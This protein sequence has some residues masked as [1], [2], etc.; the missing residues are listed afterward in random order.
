MST[1]AEPHGER[2]TPC[3]MSTKKSRSKAEVSL[4]LEEP[5]VRS[6]VAHAMSMQS[7][8]R[9]EERGTP[10]SLTPGLS[11][12]GENEL[13]IPS[14]SRMRAV[15]T[16][17]SCLT[18][19]SGGGESDLACKASRYTLL[20]LAVSGSPNQSQ[21]QIRSRITDRVLSKVTN[22]DHTHLGGT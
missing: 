12:H 7:K 8:N 16:C 17:H 9:R 20:R 19:G 14:S 21:K 3:A 2:W 11:V 18:F 1:L 6:L 22:P 13:E 15:W 4:P 10:T 5:L